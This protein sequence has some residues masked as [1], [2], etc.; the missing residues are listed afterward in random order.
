MSRLSQRI[1][2]PFRQRQQTRVSPPLSLG[3]R[4]QEK[5]AADKSSESRLYTSDSAIH[6]CTGGGVAKTRVKEAPKTT[7]LGAT[8]RRV[9]IDLSRGSQRIP[10]RDIPNSITRKT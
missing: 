3:A 2:L 1:W 7:N 10:P 6:K 4:A 5:K 9:G 8:E